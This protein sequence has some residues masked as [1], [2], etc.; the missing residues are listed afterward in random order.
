[1]TAQTNP[2]IRQLFEHR[3]D[4]NNAQNEAA[5]ASKVNQIANRTESVLTLLFDHVVNSENQVDNQTIYTLE[6]VIQE[7]RDLQEMAHYLELAIYNS[8]EECHDNKQ[9]TNLARFGGES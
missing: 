4:I 6:V 9:P 1:M 3:F 8:K 5:I 2:Q 7:L